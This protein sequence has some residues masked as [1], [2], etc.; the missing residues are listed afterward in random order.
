VQSPARTT[1]DVSSLLDIVVCRKDSHCM[2]HVVQPTHHVADH[3]LVTWSM[4]TSAQKTPRH[5]MS[6]KFLCLKKVNWA[7]FEANL[8]HSELFI[9][10]VVTADEFAV[11]LHQITSKLLDVHCPLQERRRL[12]SSRRDYR[13]LSAAAK[14][15]KRERRRLERKWQSTQRVDH[16]VAYRKSCHV[17]IKAIVDSRG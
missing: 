6:Y 12:A 7:K 9:Q 14:D 11:Q 16:Y 13:W 4:T 8:Q 15:A 17:A 5:M 10:P 2:A 3:D 1:L